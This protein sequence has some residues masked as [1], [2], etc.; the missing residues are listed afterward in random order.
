MPKLI[1]KNK[2]FQNRVMGGNR[3][4]GPSKPGGLSPIDDAIGCAIQTGLNLLEQPKQAYRNNGVSYELM[5]D[6]KHVARTFRVAL[7]TECSLSPELRS[8]SDF[9]GIEALTVR[10]PD[11][12][13]LP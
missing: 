1:E 9:L 4:D 12:Y 11:S 7:V 8:L 3:P 2:L 13:Q 6:K 10:V 5:R